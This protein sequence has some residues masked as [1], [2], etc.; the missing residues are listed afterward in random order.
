MI[1]PM[2]VSPKSSSEPAGIAM[3][4]SDDPPADGKG[5]QAKD[6]L[7]PTD[8][9][10]ES[11][12][13]DEESATEGEES[14][15]VDN[16]PPAKVDASPTPDAKDK[17]ADNDNEKVTVFY[18]TDRQ[19]LESSASR[20]W[21]YVDWVYLTAIFAAVTLVLG[22]IA[23]CHPRNRLLLA[24]ASAT[25]LGTGTLA[26]VTVRAGQETPPAEGAPS[27]VYGND[28]GTLEMGLC[29]V[30]IP[31]SHQTGEME[32]PSIFRLQFRED[33][34]R[35]IVLLSVEQ[36][37]EEEFFTAMKARVSTN[38]RRKRPWSSSTASTSTS[39]KPPCGPRN[40]PTT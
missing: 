32:R 16:G 27:R 1:A 22:A 5:P 12:A 25:V 4:I 6:P 28:R 14:A 24:L 17:K 39:K 7:A 23:Y 33:P 2:I 20:D 30:T 31:K 34:S 19:A 8:D 15:T 9:E 3:A 35:H 40:W 18:G 21:A 36:K 29:Q 37:A 11:A 10:E 13:E 38:R 26:F